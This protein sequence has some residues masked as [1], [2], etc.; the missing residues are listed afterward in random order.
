MLP[1]LRFVIGAILATV[2]LGMTALG[3]ATSVR[4]TRQ[5]TVSPLESNR[6]LAFADRAD[7]QH[8]PSS[9]AARQVPEA[10]PQTFQVAPQID[11]IVKPVATSERPDTSP[12]AAEDPVPPPVANAGDEPPVMSEPPLNNPA[13]SETDPADAGA[14]AAAAVG[15]MAMSEVPATSADPIPATRASELQAAAAEP[16]TTASIVHAEPAPESPSTPRPSAAAMPEQPEPATVAS[17]PAVV[18]EEAV[19]TQEAAPPEE[20]APAQDTTITENAGTQP[21]RVIRTRVRVHKPAPV[22][23][24]AARQESVRQESVRQ[25]S[26]RHEWVK[27]KVTVRRVRVARQQGVLPPSASTGYAVPMVPYNGS[28]RRN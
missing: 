23:K 4:L 1:D 13:P 15:T 26:V 21:E 2:V 11:D 9:E 6:S 16:S 8:L 7:W 14:P 28:Y 10:V 5:A 20:A 18:A 25:A 12:S 17:V 19:P 22:L 27:P 24:R 3:L